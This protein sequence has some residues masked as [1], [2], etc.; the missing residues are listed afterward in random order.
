MMSGANPPLC[1]PWC[2]I[3]GIAAGRLFLS[4]ADRLCFSRGTM[5]FDQVKGLGWDLEELGEFLQQ[6]VGKLS[7]KPNLSTTM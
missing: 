1:C 4:T 5:S 7:K 3:L 6:T 2:L